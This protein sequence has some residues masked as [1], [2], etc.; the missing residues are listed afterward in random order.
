MFFSRF[1]WVL[2]F[3]LDSIGFFSSFTGFSS[4]IPGSTGFYLVILGF[5]GF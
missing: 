3:F 2:L 1:S 5:I 4:V